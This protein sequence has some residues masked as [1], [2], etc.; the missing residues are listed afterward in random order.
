[1]PRHR[2]TSAPLTVT[3]ISSS[4]SSPSSSSPSSPSSSSVYPEGEC[5]YHCRYY[6]PGPVEDSK[7]SSEF[8][9]RGVYGFC[10][11]YPP[12]EATTDLTVLGRRLTYPVV[13]AT[14]WCGEYAAA[15]SPPL[16]VEKK[17]GDPGA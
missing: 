9:Q 2:P 12:Q 11:R 13:S 15:I 10:R 14:D 7:R 16:R 3:P 6:Q 4:P 8:P 17:S 5:C 1:M